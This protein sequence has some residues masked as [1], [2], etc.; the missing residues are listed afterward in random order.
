MRTFPA[1]LNRTVLFVVGLMLLI[2]GLWA[3]WPWLGRTVEVA[4][5]SWAGG[6]TADP[7]ARIAEGAPD[8]LE[9]AWSPAVVIGLG[10]VLAVLGIAWL[11][12]QLP[13]SG[14]AGTLR[15]TDDPAAGATTMDPKVLESAVADAAEA[16][17]RVSSARAV[18]RGSAGAPNLLL[19]IEAD[20]AAR[21]GELTEAL[22]TGV[23][24]DA[25]RSLGRPL[26]HLAIHYS[27]ARNASGVRTG[28][29]PA[30]GTAPRSS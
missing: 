24:A 30:A 25:A 16:L 5:P 26:E 27:V 23:A 9:L 7:E 21:L 22:E 12:R 20:P 13:R 28:L 6:I 3:L 14:R 29:Q 10:I 17:P 8:L 15:F 2:G 4:T 18:L 11:L 1:G 19:H